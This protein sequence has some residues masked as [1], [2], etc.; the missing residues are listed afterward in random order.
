MSFDT[1]LRLLTE[2]AAGKLHTLLATST[3]PPAEYEPWKCDS[4]SLISVCLPKADP[5]TGGYIDSALTRD[6]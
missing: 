5:S 4:C 3:P 1:D 6:S 2:A